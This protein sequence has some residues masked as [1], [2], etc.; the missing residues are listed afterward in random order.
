MKI[1]KKK[2]QPIFF[3]NFF[4]AKAISHIKTMLFI[5]MFTPNDFFGAFYGPKY[6]QGQ[7]SMKW[8]APLVYT[9][10]SIAIQ[11]SMLILVP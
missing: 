9:K 10:I 11:Y 5:P 1:D 8:T 4:L 3:L 2:F 6:F 7:T